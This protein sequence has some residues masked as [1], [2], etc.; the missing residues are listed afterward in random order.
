[1]VIAAIIGSIVLSEQL[2]LGRLL[3]EV[4]IFAG[5]YLV[6]WGKSNDVNHTKGEGDQ[7]PS[8]NQQ[9]PPT[10]ETGKNDP[11]ILLIAIP[12]TNEMVKKANGK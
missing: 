11:D 6:I 5:L 9:I 8:A 4:V 2:N 7:F 1:M 12:P 3:G 10:N